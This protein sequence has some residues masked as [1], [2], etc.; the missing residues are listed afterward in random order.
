MIML[1]NINMFFYISF[2]SVK[3]RYIIMLDKNS[4]IGYICT[5]LYEF[6]SNIIDCVMITIDY[7]V[8]YR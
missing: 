2:D 1:Y 8:R 5:R 6:F 3:Y 7:V 4:T